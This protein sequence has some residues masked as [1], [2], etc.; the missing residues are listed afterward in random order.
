MTKTKKQIED[1]IEE[2]RK[3]IGNFAARDLYSANCTEV[4]YLYR[5]L[6]QLE[7]ELNNEEYEEPEEDYYEPVF[8]DGSDVPIRGYY[9]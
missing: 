7:A 2:V 1:R 8:I 4:K 9:E 3:I 6:H 5:E